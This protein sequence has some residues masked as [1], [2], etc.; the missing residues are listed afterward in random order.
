MLQDYPTTG[1]AHIKSDTYYREQ[2][3]K[4][5]IHAL[6][7]LGQLHTFKNTKFWV[8]ACRQSLWM[9]AKEYGYKKIRV[10]SSKSQ[11]PPSSPSQS[12]DEYLSSIRIE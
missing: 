6:A 9:A 8:I 12:D 5:G 7:W 11:N 1:N 2:V 3:A 10:P 4:S